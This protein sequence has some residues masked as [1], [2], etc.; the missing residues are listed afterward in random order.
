MFKELLQTRD[1]GTRVTRN[2]RIQEKEETG[3]S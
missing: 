2:G 3:E 1:C